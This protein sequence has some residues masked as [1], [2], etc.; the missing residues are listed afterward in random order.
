MGFG[1]KNFFKLG[2]SCFWRTE[3]RLEKVRL[4]VAKPQIAGRGEVRVVFFEN[5]VSIEFL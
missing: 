3:G 1:N 2:K 5:S 4:T